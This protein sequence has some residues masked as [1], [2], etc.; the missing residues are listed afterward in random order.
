MRVLEG[1]TTSARR[2]GQRDGYGKRRNL[3][4]LGQTAGI[5]DCVAVLN[6]PDVEAQFRSRNE[7]HEL[8]SIRVDHVPAIPLNEALKLHRSADRPGG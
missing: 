1:L 5:Y 2:E 3:S 7:V 8:G 4:T 6:F